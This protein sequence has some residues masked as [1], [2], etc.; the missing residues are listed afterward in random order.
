MLEYL[1]GVERGGAAGDRYMLGWYCS[2][3]SLL[4]LDSYRSLL[5]YKIA[6][7]TGLRIG[8]FWSHSIRDPYADQSRRN[9][10]K[11]PHWNNTGLRIGLF[12]YVCT[13]T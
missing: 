6:D 3:G 12:L 7:Q 9:K 11:N 2:R 5:V 1:E 4:R 8:L 10:K 13:H